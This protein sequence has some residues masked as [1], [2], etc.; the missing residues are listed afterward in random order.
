M[1]PTAAGG[2]YDGGRLFELATEVGN[3]ATAIGTAAATIAV[4]TGST[5]D[6]SA[7]FF[8]PGS[9]DPTVEAQALAIFGSLAEVGAL[10]SGT[11]AGAGTVPGAVTG[12]TTDSITEIIGACAAAAILPPPTANAL[13]AYAILGGPQALYPASTAP[14]ARDG[15]VFK[16]ESAR[17][18]VKKLVAGAF[19]VGDGATT[20]AKGIIDTAGPGAAQLADGLGDAADGAGQLA[21][22]VGTIAGGTV[23]LSEAIEGTLVGGT[24]EAGADLGL[25]LAQLNAADARGIEN[26]GLPY[27]TVANADVS[28]VYAF[29][30]AGVGGE[31]GPSSAT[32]ALA[33]LIALAL[34]ALVGLALR[35]RAG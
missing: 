33:A 9:G 25:R 16:L 11:G 30:I 35:N 18:D 21:E 26:E 3:E 4:V 15:A 5:P 28:A 29:E 10:M 17:A 13:Y 27:G 34:A 8:V 20:L 6:A 14:D 31:S 1:P 24:T 32:L 19:A 22:G 12:D 7:P 23:A 2:A